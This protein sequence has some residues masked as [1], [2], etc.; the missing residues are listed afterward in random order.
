M[1]IEPKA[2]AIAQREDIYNCLGAFNIVSIFYTIGRQT[3]S[4]FAITMLTRL[5]RWVSLNARIFAALGAYLHS[6]GV[7]Y[8]MFSPYQVRKHCHP[9]SPH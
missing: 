7:G 6:F 4:S 9:Q 1:L 2:L 8:D 3:L 5:H